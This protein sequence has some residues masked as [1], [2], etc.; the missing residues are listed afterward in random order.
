[1]IVQDTDADKLVGKHNGAGSEREPNPPIA[2]L[3][4]RGLN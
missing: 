2:G 1:M 4:G 3:P